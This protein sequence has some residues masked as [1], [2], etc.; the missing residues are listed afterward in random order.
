MFHFMGAVMGMML[1]GVL[2]LTLLAVL[3]FKALRGNGS[4]QDSEESESEARMI[5]EIYNSL[6]RMENRIEA[7][8]T[9]ILDQ[10]SDQ[11]NGR[12]SRR[13]NY[14]ENDDGMRTE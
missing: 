11:G 1:I 7:L 14:E 4:G 2:V 5:Q 13:D 9:L 12:K 10:D 6:N 3:V 8:E